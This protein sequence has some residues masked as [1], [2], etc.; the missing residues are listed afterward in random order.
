[1]CA[2]ALLR[3]VVM[4]RVE[5]MAIEA[6]AEFHFKYDWENARTAQSPIFPAIGGAQFHGQN[7]Q[8]SNWIIP[9]LV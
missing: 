2:A 9:S 7:A 4:L 5:L 3:E 6:K 8:S 1:M